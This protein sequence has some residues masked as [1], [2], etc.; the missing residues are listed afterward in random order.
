MNIG[1][2]WWHEGPWGHFWSLKVVFWKRLVNREDTPGLSLLR[3]AVLHPAPRSTTSQWFPKRSASSISHKSWLTFG[4]SRASGAR[5]MNL[6]YDTYH[7]ECWCWPAPDGAWR[8]TPLEKY[9]LG[10]KSM[11]TSTAGPS[12]RCTEDSSEDLVMHTGATAGRTWVE[13][14]VLRSGHHPLACWGHGWVFPR[15]PTPNN[16]SNKVCKG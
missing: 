16:A 10:L 4:F 9:S 13:G 15:T 6:H 7:R 8:N 2:G 1:S 12:R 3:L 5:L 11:H 14:V